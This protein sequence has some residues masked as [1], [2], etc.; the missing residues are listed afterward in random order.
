MRSVNFHTVEDEEQIIGNLSILIDG[1]NKKIG[2]EDSHHLL[3]QVL[4]KQYGKGLLSI[5]VVPKTG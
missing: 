2:T 4:E 5:F 1:I 3:K